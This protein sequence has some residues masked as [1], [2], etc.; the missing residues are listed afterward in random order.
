MALPEHSCV[1]CAYLCQKANNFYGISLRNQILGNKNQVWVGADYKYLICYKRKLPS[2]YLSGKTS[3]EIRDII[4]AP[5]TCKQWIQF[6]NGI[7]PVV[8][9]QSQSSKWAKWAFWASII[10]ATI[11]LIAILLT[12]S[13]S[14][15]IF[16]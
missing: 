12:W 10:T 11:M 13:L 4:I 14:Q 9:E 1:S 2:F 16:D 5:N 15:F 7:S 3:D 8:T 6:I